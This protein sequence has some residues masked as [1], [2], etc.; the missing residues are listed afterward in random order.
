[1][2]HGEA[3]VP[4]LAVHTLADA[5]NV[6]RNFQRWVELRTPGPGNAVNR[7][8]AAVLREMRRRLGVPVLRGD[9]ESAGIQGRP[10]RGVDD[11]NDRF[12][13]DDNQAASGIGEVV[14]DV[15]DQQ[16]GALVVSAHGADGTRAALRPS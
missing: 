11:R 4:I 2:A 6:D 3:R 10:N 9:H 13:A 5:R 1:M 14:L 8:D 16:R 12:P 15:G 7:P